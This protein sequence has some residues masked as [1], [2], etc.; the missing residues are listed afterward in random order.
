MNFDLI[1]IKVPREVESHSQFRFSGVYLY[2]I[3]QTFT[4]R[5]NLDRSDNFD[6]LGLGQLY[7]HNQRFNNRRQG[8]KTRGVDHK[9][10][11]TM[12]IDR[13]S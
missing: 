5:G 6:L 11:M 12:T 3:F 13:D 1:G 9:R 2:K 10:E 4:V 8:E 7:G